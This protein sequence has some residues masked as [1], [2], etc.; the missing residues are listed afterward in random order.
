MFCIETRTTCSHFLIYI[1]ESKL[2]IN[3]NLYE[4]YFDCDRFVNFISWH[5][6]IPI[7]ITVVIRYYSLNTCPMMHIQCHFSRENN[8]NEILFL[9]QAGNT[10]PVWAVVWI[11]KSWTGRKWSALVFCW[12]LSDI[13][14]GT[15]LH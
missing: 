10:F 12:G 6:F 14:K 8:R 9:T 1:L 15:W 5:A 7:F 13:L 3:W 2:S 4:T 11:E